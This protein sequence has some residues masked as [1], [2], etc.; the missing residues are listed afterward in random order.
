MP[1]FKTRYWGEP[2]P[3][4]Y[5]KVCPIHWKSKLPLLL[6]QVDKF[7]PTE[8]TTSLGRAQSW[9]TEEVSL[10]LNTMP[11]FA[12]RLSILSTKIYGSTQ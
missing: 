3:I 4:Y 8:V 9:V 5:K 12:G 11:G 10:E 2:F 7:L 1:F 6:P